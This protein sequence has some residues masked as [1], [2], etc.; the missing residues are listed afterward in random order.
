MPPTIITR[1]GQQVLEQPALVA[2]AAFDAEVTRIGQH[3]PFVLING[4]P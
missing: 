4:R 1:D 2:K 3:A